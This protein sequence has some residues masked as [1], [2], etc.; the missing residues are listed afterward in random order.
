MNRRRE[1]PRNLTERRRCRRQTQRRSS[2]QSACRLSR[3]TWRTLERPGFGWRLTRTLPRKWV[4]SRK[5]PCPPR[6]SRRRTMATDYAR[7]VA[8][9][10]IEQLKAGT[11][12]WQ[13][14]W[15]PGE[16]FM[17]YNPTTGKDYRGGKPVWLVG[18][19]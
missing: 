7:K 9:G 8:E 16:Q 18:A 1:A 6:T 17:P 14:P 13:K 3:L 5:L 11:A 15:Q 4:R 10:L 19:G 12:P 2:A